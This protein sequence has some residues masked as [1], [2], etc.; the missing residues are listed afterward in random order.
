MNSRATA[1]LPLDPGADPIEHDIQAEA[2]RRSRGVFAP[3]HR[4]DRRADAARR[5]GGCRRDRSGAHPRA[6]TAIASSSCRT[7]AGWKATSRHRAPSSCGST[8]RASIRSTMLRCAFALSRIVRE[9]RCDLIHA[10]GRAAAWSGYIAARMPA[11]AA[12]HHLVQGLPRAERVQAPLQRRDGARRARG[13]GVGPDRRA[14]RRALSHSVRA[15]RG[16]AGEHR[17]RAL[18]SGGGLGRARSRRSAAPGA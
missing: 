6:A 2:A 15:H 8:S 4:A 16:G 7:A 11:R 18:R 1:R 5:R 13:R 3:A 17:S 12:A 9:K 14:D 10:H